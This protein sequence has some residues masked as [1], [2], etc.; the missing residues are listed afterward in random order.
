MSHIFSRRWLAF[1]LACVAFAMTCG[2]FAASPSAQAQD[3]LESSVDDDTEEIASDAVWTARV[4]FQAGWTKGNRVPALATYSPPGTTRLDAGVLGTSGVKVWAGAEQ[5]DQAMR[6]GVRAS[7]SRRLASVPGVSLDLGGVFVGDDGSVHD[8]QFNSPGSPII[9]RPFYNAVTA[10]ED[11]ELVAYPDV[12]AGTVTI[13]SRSEIVSPEIALSYQLPD[14]WL[15]RI[16]LSGGYRYFRLSDSLSIRED[17]ESID[18]GG[19]IPLGTVTIVEDR[20][21]TRNEF[22]GAQV[23]ANFEFDQDL[24][25]LAFLGKL[26][27]GDLRRTVD[28]QGDT[29]VAIPALPATTTAGGLLAQ[30]TNIGRYGSSRFAVL[31]EFGVQGRLRLTRRLDFTLGYSL[32]LLNDV[33][34]S[35]AQV[36][37]VVNPTQIGAQ[38]LVG[39]A[40]PRFELVDS[41]FWMQSLNLG[42][43]F[44]W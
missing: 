24:W 5:L 26:A 39:P 19:L 28:I 38:P 16:S 35:G 42:A 34:R 33:A 22:H 3:D 18:Q 30:S 27:M 15:G 29:V 14:E 7:L 8:Y 20:F 10:R 36:D 43:E 40:R 32:L 17:L 1:S 37:R 31:P 25:S 4:D 9:S 41:D 11:A 12:L 21:K 23:G 6:P 44:R 2:P 13:R